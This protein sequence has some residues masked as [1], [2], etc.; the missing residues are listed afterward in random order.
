MPWDPSLLL[1]VISLPVPGIRS[2]SNLLLKATM[3][4]LACVTLKAVLL[5]YFLF[6]G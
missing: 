4:G 5:F 6:I 3:L 1:L 2:S